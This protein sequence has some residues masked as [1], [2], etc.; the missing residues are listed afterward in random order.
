MLRTEVVSASE[1]FREASR[2][3][4]SVR[5]I[6]DERPEGVAPP[7]WCEA[8]GWTAFLEAM[9]DDA[10]AAASRT[11]TA[12]PEPPRTSSPSATR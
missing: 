11:S 6:V 10:V 4:A 12:S 5:D 1:H 3:L 9:P 2:L 8:R 7:S